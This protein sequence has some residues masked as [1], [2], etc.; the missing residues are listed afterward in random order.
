MYSSPTIVPREK[1]STPSSNIHPATL[2]S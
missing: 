2:H 1:A